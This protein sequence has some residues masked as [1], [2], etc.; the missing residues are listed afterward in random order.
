MGSLRKGI[1]RNILSA[2]YFVR[3]ALHEVP[4]A[5]ELVLSAHL[6]RQFRESLWERSRETHQ[7]HH[8]IYHEQA[9]VEMTSFLLY[10][11]V[12]NSFVNV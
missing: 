10:D 11:A 8:Q 1:L 3:S 4:C 5:F 9:A 7:V 2:K 12:M 6:T